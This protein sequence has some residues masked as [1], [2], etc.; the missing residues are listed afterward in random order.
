MSDDTPNEPLLAAAALIRSCRRSHVS[1]EFIKRGLGI[2][3]PKADGLVQQLLAAGVIGSR[4]PAGHPILPLAAA[5]VDAPA[6]ILPPSNRGAAGPPAWCSMARV[7]ELPAPEAPP[8]DGDV[9]NLHPDD[10]TIHATV[11]P[12]VGLDE[13]TVA[14]YGERMTDGDVF[15]PVIAF[16]TGEA[17]VLADGFHRVAAAKRAGLHAITARV[18]HGTLRDAVLHA[19]RENLTHGLP[20]TAAERRA[21]ARRLLADPEWSQ[22]SDREIARHCGLTSM[23][24]GRLRAGAAPEH[25]NNVKAA[26]RKYRAADG[27]VRTMDVSRLGRKPRPLPVVVTE[28]SAGEPTEHDGP[29]VDAPPINGVRVAPT[30]HEEGNGGTLASAQM[31]IAQI[32]ALTAA[33]DELASLIRSEPHLAR[34]LAGRV[35]TLAALLPEC[36]AHTRR[37]LRR[38]FRADG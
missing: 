28:A 30:A 1:A 18:K 7:P 37:Q 38:S 26:P 27:R 20:M 9:R 16:A 35:A 12:R 5:E 10:F 13:A 24:I 36:P 32:D 19:L 11:Q 21:G 3:L 6:P 31:L 34:R 2:S 8:S 22:W 23:S 14:E 15:P 4:T 29:S 25:L 17:L 33:P